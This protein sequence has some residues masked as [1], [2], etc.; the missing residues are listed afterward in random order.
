MEIARSSG[1]SAGSDR[2][3]HSKNG[4][5]RRYVVCAPIAAAKPGILV[6]TLFTIDKA[7]LEVHARFLLNK[8]VTSTR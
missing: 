5:K 2:I 4:G 1:E 6:S 8:R 3:G 7:M